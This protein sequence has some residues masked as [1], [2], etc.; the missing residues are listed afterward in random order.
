MT[1]F[2]K[3]LSGN[4]YGDHFAGDRWWRRFFGRR[5]F[6]NSHQHDSDTATS[7]LVT[8]V[9]DEMCCGDIQLSPTSM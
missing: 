4:F 2:C 8:D 3:K 9:G 7:M 6:L 5:F 1:S